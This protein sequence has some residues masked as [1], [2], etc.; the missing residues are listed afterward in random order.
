MQYKEY[1]IN[2]TN[3]FKTIVELNNEGDIRI[4]DYNAYDDVAYIPLNQ[5]DELINISQ[6]I[7]QQG[8]VL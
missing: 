1:T 6:K 8:G 3:G 7:K 5:I 2:G 4:T